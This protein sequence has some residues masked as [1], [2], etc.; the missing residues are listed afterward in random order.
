M[1]LA[2]CLRRFME[3]EQLEEGNQWE[4]DACKDHCRAYKRLELWSTPNVLCINLKRFSTYQA[5]GMRTVRRRKLNTPI[6]LPL[7]FDLRE[8]TTGPMLDGLS[9]VYDI[10]GVVNHYGDLTSG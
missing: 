3:K 7:S 9:T 2:D 1:D 5:F 4:C 8:F 10:Y 6:N